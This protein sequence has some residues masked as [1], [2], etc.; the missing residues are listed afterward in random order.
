M[1]W[2]S[3]LP[4]DGSGRLRRNVIDHAV[5]ALHFVN[6]AAGDRLQHV[7]RQRNPVSGHA[8]LRTDG[9]DSTGVRVSP[10]VAHDAYRHHRKPHGKWL[11]GLGIEPGILDLADDDV[12]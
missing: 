12:V 10:P 11:A 7:V 8:I 9:T 4:L 5:Y 1:S 6:D 3:S 2:L